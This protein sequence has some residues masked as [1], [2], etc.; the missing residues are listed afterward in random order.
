MT[1]EM[2]LR[3]RAL[4]ALEDAWLALAA[5]EAPWVPANGRTR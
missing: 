4:F 1:K 5:T 3:W 2:P